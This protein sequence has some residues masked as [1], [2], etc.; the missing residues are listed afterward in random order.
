MPAGGNEGLN[1]ETSSRVIGL[2]RIFH[3]LMVYKPIFEVKMDKVVKKL[4]NQ[5]IHDHGIDIQ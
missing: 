2:I 5:A 3:L 4:E 1:N